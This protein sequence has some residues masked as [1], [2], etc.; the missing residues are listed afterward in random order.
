[1]MEHDDGFS[2]SIGAFETMLVHDGRCIMFVRHMDRLRRALES[3]GVGNRVDPRMLEDEVSD[4][5]LD[6]RV[7][8]VEVSERN[9]VISDRP[10]PYSDGDYARGFR[11]RIP[12]VRRNES[13]PFTYMK[14]LQYG[15]S[16]MEKR[17][18]KADG[19][20]EPLFLN[21][22]GEIC[23]GATTNIFFSKGGRLYTPEK[24]CGLLPG[25]VRSYVM[26]KFGAEEG[27]FFPEDLRGFDGCF[28]T[29]SVLGIM[30]VASI[31]G[32]GFHDRSLCDGIRKTYLR[33]VEDGL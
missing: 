32:V 16:I 2:F 21:C 7:L 27:V 17:K 31:D 3:L 29:N 1:M 33:D 8:K 12:E 10:V 24:R 13:S 22:R 26:E 23:E 6:G 14:S 18:A 9:V 11:L 20:D 30:P 4:G 19:F 5:H 25:T 15:D 28:V